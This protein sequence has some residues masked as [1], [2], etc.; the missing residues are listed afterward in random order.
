MSTG[1]VEITVNG[2]KRFVSVPLTVEQFLHELGFK[3]GQVVVEYNG[4]ILSKDKLQLE[5]LQNGDSIELI[6]PVAGG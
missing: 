3:A 4:N 6:I 5:M 2:G 1:M